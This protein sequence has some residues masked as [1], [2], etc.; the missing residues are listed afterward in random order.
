MNSYKVKQII[1]P[2]KKQILVP[3]SKS[4]T[5]RAYLLAAIWV[6]KSIIKNSL[7]S[8]DTVFMLKALNRL[9]AWIVEYNKQNE[10]HIWGFWWKVKKWPHNLFLWNAWTAVRFLTS[11][12]ATQTEKITV[13]W[14]KRMRERPLWD[15]V[16]W[17]QNLWALVQ[18]N[19]WFPPVQIT[20]SSDLINYLTIKWNTSSQ[21][22]S[23]LLLIAP[24][25]QSWL[26]IKIDWELV[27]KPYI[28][29]TIDV[30]RQF[31]IFIE[32]D[33]YKIFKIEKQNYASTIFSV[34]ADA[35]SASYW[36]ALAAIT[37]SDLTINLPYSSKQWDTK[38][39]DI[40][41]RIWA[42][43]CKNNDSI[44]I[45]WSKDLK[46]IWTIDMNTMPDAAMTL[47]VIAPLLPWKTIITN[48]A[49]MRVKETDRIHAIVT[50]LKKLWVSAKELNDWIEINHCDNFKKWI[51]IETYNDHRMAM[52]F[53]ILWSKIWWLEILDP[54]CCSKT[55]PSFFQ[56][57]DDF[58]K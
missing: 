16:L 25:L 11:L 41:E 34:E 56:E 50:E 55:Y 37:E 28:D 42:K 47:A 57:L 13:D 58:S 48:V 17:V 31:N 44:N 26:E 10:I 36:E 9:W 45:I 18:S 20:W 53:A 43:I 3:W 52:C 8:D 1:S 14:D 54:G 22:L 2:V 35:S 49:N 23:G 30:L 51:K 33:N 5:N 29:L 15:L 32:N 6:W 24:M 38:F 12:A 40:M 21:Y 46:S 4:I 39:V 7:R 27:S 19:N